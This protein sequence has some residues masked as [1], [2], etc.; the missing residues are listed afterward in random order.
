MLITALVTRD[1]CYGFAPWRWRRCVGFFVLAAAQQIFR[2]RD[3]PL[4]IALQFAAVFQ[5]LL[6]LIKEIGGS[7]KLTNCPCVMFGRVTTLL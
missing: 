6:Q 4:D 2:Q 5:R 3:K 1:G 7:Q